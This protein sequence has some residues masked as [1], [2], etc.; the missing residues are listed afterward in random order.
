MKV[1]CRNSIVRFVYINGEAP[2]RQLH[3]IYVAL[4]ES[5]PLRSLAWID[6]SPIGLRELRRALINVSEPLSEDNLPYSGRM[7]NRARVKGRFLWPKRPGNVGRYE[8][9]SWK[10]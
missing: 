7:K 1:P 8:V 2:C 9:E 4:V 10:R 6:P 5:D 3:I